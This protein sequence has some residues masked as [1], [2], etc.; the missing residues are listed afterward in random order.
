MVETV[1]VRII[2]P[3]RMNDAAFRRVLLDALA[4]IDRGVHK[5]YEGTT[6][7]WKHKVKFEHGHSLTASRGRAFCET[8]DE[9][10]HYVNDGT[11]GKGKGPTYPIPKT[12]KVKGA[13]KFQWG[14]KGSYRAKTAPRRFNSRP[15]GPSGPWVAFK[16]V[17]HPGIEPR[18]FDLI[19]FKRWDTLVPRALKDA[20]GKAA[21]ASGHGIP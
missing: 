19:I 11:A 12:P 6:S 13:L 15:G 16:Q 1:K 9:I 7:T 17:Q 3:K 14:G 5:D 20:L 8:N 10:Y 21:V 2:K 4:D 18:E